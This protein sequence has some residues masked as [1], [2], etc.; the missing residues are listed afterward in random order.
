MVGWE[1]RIDRCIVFDKVGYICQMCKCKTDPS[2]D[3]NA[4]LYPNLDHI[5][6]LAQ[7]GHHTWD[8]VQCLCRACNIFKSDKDM[9]DGVFSY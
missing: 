5:V 2:L 4:N 7:G 8:N 3:V 9:C 6:A 1:E